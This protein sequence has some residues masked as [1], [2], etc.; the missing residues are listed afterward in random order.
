MNRYA[1]QLRR[2]RWP[3]LALLTLLASGAAPLTIAAVGEPR[4]GASVQISE[5]EARAAFERGEQALEEGRA[6]EAVEAFRRVLEFVPEDFGVRFR[7]G[8]ALFLAGDPE[9]IEH[10]DYAF[11]ASGR[12]PEVAFVLA[13][14]QV[15][16]ARYSE[17]GEALDAVE[18]VAPDVPD[19]HLA[20]GELCY[21]VGRTRAAAEHLERASDLG[22][23]GWHA[24]LYRLGLVHVAEREWEEATT[25]LERAVQANPGHLDSWLLLA[26][27]RNRAGDPTGSTYAME[28]AVQT[29]P[30]DLTA[31]L[32]LAERYDFMD[33][34]EPLREQVDAILALDPG[35]PNALLYRADRALLEG[36][37]E[38]ALTDLEQ[39][40]ARGSSTPRGPARLAAEGTIVT[41]SQL[42]AEARRRRVDVLARRGR[43]EEAIDAARALV[44]DEPA[45]AEGW[46]A[47]GNLLVRSGQPEEGRRYLERFQAMSRAENR[48]RMGENFLETTDDPEL[49]E[50]EFE[51]AVR[52]WSEDRRALLGLAR[53][54]RLQ[55]RPDEALT[56]L[57]KARG[58]A[59][60]VEDWYAETI[61]SLAAAGR[62]SDALRTWEEGRRLGLPFGP[63]VWQVVYT[64]DYGCE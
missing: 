51:G 3:A 40:L 5:A 41:D 50:T 32:V 16:S 12:R 46:F 26:T 17:A 4:A 25:W 43:T 33:A 11:E 35:N 15:A 52:A 62:I 53:V 48:R 23:P 60:A 57:E 37:F 14:A 20:R 34:V 61:L 59:R 29:A 49:A 31:R 63:E 10:L 54:R 30:D 6:I 27:A 42:R 28:R 36:R 55:G 1:P 21:L 18:R 2:V 64:D 39:L 13:Q 47:L 38:E 7:L 44:A 8:Q 58:A 9:A 24:P 22:S 19:V 45:F 56:L